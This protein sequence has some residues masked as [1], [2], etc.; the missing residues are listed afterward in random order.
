M[1]LIVN[2]KEKINDTGR[3]GCSRIKLKVRDTPPS[4]PLMSTKDLSL[5]YPDP[6]VNFMVNQTNVT[7]T[8]KC[9]I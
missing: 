6:Y 5:G 1:L 4:F 8:A 7:G 2:N 9:I 3:Q